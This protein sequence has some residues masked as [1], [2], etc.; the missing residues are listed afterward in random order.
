MI[1]IVATAGSVTDLT[2]KRR[3]NM[4][5]RDSINNAIR[6][7]RPESSTDIIFLFLGFIL[8]MLWVYSNVHNR[9]IV[10]LVVLVTFMGSLKAIKVGSDFQKKRKATTNEVSPEVECPPAPDCK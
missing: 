6:S 2:K 8:G 1:G 7:D 4:R 3:T 10:S 9:E 5:L